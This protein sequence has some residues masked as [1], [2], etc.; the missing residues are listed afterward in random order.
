MLLGVVCGLDTIFCEREEL[1]LARQLEIK[2]ANLNHTLK[3]AKV[4]IF[5]EVTEK[6]H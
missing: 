4:S 3:R 5:Y 6:G 1:G 2:K